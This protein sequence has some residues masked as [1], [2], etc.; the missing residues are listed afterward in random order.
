MRAAQIFLLIGLL[1]GC[2]A[3]RSDSG[4]AHPDLHVVRVDDSEREGVDPAEVTVLTYV[5]GQRLISGC[6]M[7]ARLVMESY[8][9]GIVRN[10][11][12]RK[13]AELGATVVVMSELDQELRHAGAS[14]AGMGTQVLNTR[15]HID[16]LDCT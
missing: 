15:Y 4:S 1:A 3:P 10:A 8:S 6:T 12:V 2:S 9:A 13:A 11:A 16:A 7:I 5:A 14:R